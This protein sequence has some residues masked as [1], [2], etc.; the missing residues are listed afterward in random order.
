MQF[1]LVDRNLKNRWIRGADVPFCPD[2][3][4]ITVCTAT[5]NCRL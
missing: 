3:S 5:R 2:L 1:Q 4:L